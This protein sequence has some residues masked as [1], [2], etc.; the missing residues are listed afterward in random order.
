MIGLL[1]PS[2]TVGSYAKIYLF[3]RK[4][5]KSKIKT[6]KEA[7]KEQKLRPKHYEDDGGVYM[8]PEAPKRI[9]ERR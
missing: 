5:I 2:L 1:I 3:N 7:L 9:S 4:R 8:G 6:Q